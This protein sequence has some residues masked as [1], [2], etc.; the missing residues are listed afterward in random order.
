MKSLQFAQLR[1]IATM[2]LVL[3]IETFL[4][5][6]LIIG[7]GF[8]FIFIS[9]FIIMM[10]LITQY[11]VRAQLELLGQLNRIRKAY[12]I[13]PISGFDTVQKEIKSISGIIG[14]PNTDGTTENSQSLKP[15]FNASVSPGTSRSN[16]QHIQQ[17]SQGVTRAQRAQEDILK[18]L[19]K[20]ESELITEI[21]FQQTST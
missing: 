20:I 9:P 1:I 10:V 13:N 17:S 3:G 5:T 8:N 6:K 14:G 15:I 21:K 12:N 19:Y 16:F 7:L 18:L 4:T 11:I 2:L